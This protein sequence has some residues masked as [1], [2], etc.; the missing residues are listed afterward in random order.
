M[1]KY[2]YDKLRGRIIEKFH[3]V[4]EFCEPQ[5]LDMAKSGMYT[6][7]K[8]GKPFPG[9]LVGKMAKLLEIEPE[10]IG[11]YFFASMFQ[12]AKQKE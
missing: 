12:T 4:S 6:Y 2:N 3:S 11:I 8:T 10:D 5:N 7:L 1:D 9:A